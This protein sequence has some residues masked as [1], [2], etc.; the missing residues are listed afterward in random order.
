[1]NFS[2]AKEILVIGVML[3]IWLAVIFFASYRSLVYDY[4]AGS[5]SNPPARWPQAAALDRTPGFFTIVMFVHPKCSCS[6]AS[7]GELAR[8]MTLHQTRLRAQVIFA[9]PKG[10][11]ISWPENAHWLAA[12]SISGTQVVQDTDGHIAQVFGAQTSGYTLVYD[13]EGAL[14]FTGGI[15]ASRGHAGDNAGS[16]AI[17]NILAS[18]TSPI[19]KTAV[20][21]CNLVK[22]DEEK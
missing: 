8:L 13:K 17:H 7:I 6:R 15:T 9:T 18:G 19:Q 4:T 1:M 20:F 10:A 2:R 5:G 11:R 12:Q 22:R 3:L 16:A 14:V 21:G